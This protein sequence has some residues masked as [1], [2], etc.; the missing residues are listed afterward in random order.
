M[1]V[2]ANGVVSPNQRLGDGA[3]QRFAGGFMWFH[4]C[5]RAPRDRH[6]AKP[7]TAWVDEFVGHG[8]SSDLL[9]KTQPDMGQQQVIGAWC[10][11]KRWDS[12]RELMC[13]R[14]QTVGFAVSVAISSSK[15]CE[16][17]NIRCHIHWTSLNITPQ[18]GAGIISKI[19]S[20]VVRNQSES[21][22]GVLPLPW[23]CVR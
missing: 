12:N 1:I 3:I 18:L 7:F 2:F 20:G 21:S 4:A 16:T 19:H 17:R 9:A 6:L 14:R 22:C 10:Q 11:R 13:V 15:G 5:D 8:D 23:I